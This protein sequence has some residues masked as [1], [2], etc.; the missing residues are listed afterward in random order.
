MNHYGQG[1]VTLWDV[2]SS[3][4]WLPRSTVKNQRQYDWGYIAA[5]CIGRAQREY[6]VR[7]MYLEF[8]NVSDPDDV[9]V[10]PDFTRADGRE[11]Y[12]NLATDS[13]GTA[14]Y[15]RVPLLTEPQ[16]GIV[17]GYED[18]FESGETGNQLTF[19]A[20][21]SAS[22]AEGMG[23]VLFG[24]TVNSKIY[25]AA[26]VAAPGGSDHTQDLIFARAYYEAEAQILKAVTGQCGISWDLGFEESLT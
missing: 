13:G 25:G 3:G 26:V 5:Q 17:P 24:S 11:Y 10:A 18:Y 20:Q 7:Y 12:A 9:V 21:T 23:G 19:F 14:D 6:A 2:Q 16:I 22:V 1:R 4:L 8:A 15:L